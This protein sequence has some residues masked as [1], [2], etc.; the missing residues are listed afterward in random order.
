M[1]SFLSTAALTSDR[2]NDSHEAELLELRDAIAEAKPEDLA[3]L[4][5]QMTRISALAAG[6]KGKTAGPIDQ[7][8]PYFGHLRLR[9]TV[10][11]KAPSR[12]VLIGRRGVIDR[13]AGI[14]IVEDRKS[15]V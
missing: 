14:Q 5:E 6:R 10:P 2:K 7:Q 1:A 9:A 8:A 3:P 11:A 4:V 12:D 15:V 13:A